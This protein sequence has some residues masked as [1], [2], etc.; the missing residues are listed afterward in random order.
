MNV[1]INIR[2]R[3]R[4]TRI[5]NPINSETEAYHVTNILITKEKESECPDHDK[6]KTKAVE[7]LIMGNKIRN[8]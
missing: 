8:N 5:W 6:V 2:S 7:K 3:E 4:K 1:D